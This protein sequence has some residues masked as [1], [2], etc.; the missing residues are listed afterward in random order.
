M[1]EQGFDLLDQPVRRVAGLDVPVP[2]ALPLEEYV[3]PSVERIVQA[4]LDLG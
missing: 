4:A 1:N 3:L 2:F